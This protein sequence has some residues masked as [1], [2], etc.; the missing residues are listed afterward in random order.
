M[1]APGDAAPR[2][3]VF[4]DRESVIAAPRKGS[5]GACPATGRPK[6]GHSRG[7]SSTHA[8]GVFLLA[9]IAVAAAQAAAECEAFNAGSGESFWCVRGRGAFTADE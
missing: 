3:S 6:F 5:V 2:G 7:V 8:A 9:L 1:A 4:K